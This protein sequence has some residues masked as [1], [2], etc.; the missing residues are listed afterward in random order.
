[1][2]ARTRPGSHLA[3][4]KCPLVL[5]LPFPNL[6]K[7]TGKEIIKLGSDISSIPIASKLRSS[8]AVLPYLEKR[9]QTLQNLHRGSL[10]L[11][12][13]E[14][15]GMGKDEVQELVELNSN[16]IASY[17]NTEGSDYESDSD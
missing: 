17:R 14:G 10:G 8:S 2:D 3:S 7:P 16:V 9:L 4:S 15:W 12:I 13:L 6:F 5:P 11:Q 1:M